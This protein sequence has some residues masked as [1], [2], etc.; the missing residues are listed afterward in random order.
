M[1]KV[2][3]GDWVTCFS[4]REAARGGHV[5]SVRRVARDGSWADVDWGE[6]RKRM[7][8]QYLRVEATIG[9]VGE[10][11]GWEVTD[12]TREREIAAGGDDWV[13]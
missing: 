7:P 4:D 9:L 3:R 8:T 10:M 11:D 5:G 13:G 6:W 2:K 1:V 12:L